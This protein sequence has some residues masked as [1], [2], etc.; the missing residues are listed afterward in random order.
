MKKLA[1]III[2]LSLVSCNSGKDYF[3]ARMAVQTDPSAVIEKSQADDIA[4]VY[5][6]TQT[7]DLKM[8]DETF[9]FELT[10]DELKSEFQNTNEEQVTESWEDY[11]R[12]KQLSSG[13]TKKKAKKNRKRKNKR[14]KR[15]RYRSTWD[16]ADL[17]EFFL[18]LLALLIIFWFISELL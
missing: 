3:N 16:I 7:S 5:P 13:K 1:Y 6:E 18:G 2:G 12:E 15:K 10:I 14:E 9:E 17:Y 11:D 4:G 8:L